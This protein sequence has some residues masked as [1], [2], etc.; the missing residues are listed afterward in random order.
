MGKLGNE[1]A[2]GY[3]K[4]GEFEDF[5]V[6]GTTLDCYA[7][8]YVSTVL[9]T[10]LSSHI[11]YICLFIRKKFMFPKYYVLLIA[12]VLLSTMAE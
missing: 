11:K 7:I 1:I 4:I 6:S 9:L 3:S 10:T 5:F 12:L 2:I 8:P